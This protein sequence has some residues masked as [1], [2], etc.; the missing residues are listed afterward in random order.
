[1]RFTPA[2]VL[3]L[4]ATGLARAGDC[5]PATVDDDNFFQSGVFADVDVVL[6]NPYSGDEINVA[7]E[8]L[9]PDT[10]YDGME[11]MDII[12]GSNFNDAIIS[13]TLTPPPP[14]A[15]SV[16]SIEVI[17][18]GE[19]DDLVVLANPLGPYMT[20]PPQQPGNA[21]VS[22][23]GGSGNEII[24]LDATNDLAS[25]GSGSDHIDGGPGDDELYGDAGNDTVRGGD[26]NDIV[27]GG[28]GVNT[29]MGD[30]GSDT[31]I[32]LFTEGVTT[33]VEPPDGEI[34]A[35]GFLNPVA[36]DLFTYFRRGDD[37]IVV[38]EGGG[39]FII[40][41]QYS[42]PGRG[43]D[44]LRYDDAQPAI[45]LRGVVATPVGPCPTD[46][47][48]DCVTGSSDLAVLLASWG[49]EGAD[50]DNDG[51]TSSTDLAILLAAWGSCL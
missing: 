6:V 42:E 26:G 49:A 39:K 9:I 25:G 44:E 3:F 22:V 48:G 19:G 15:G 45:D 31:F 2:L 27:V 36:S 10:C 5:E 12:L 33:I 46:L 41:G 43:V 17:F 21:R 35:I 11:G 28:P 29:V 8:L 34:D 50:L 23:F 7:S 20:S 14:L 38:V 47:D 16:T 51:I 37:L 24:W 40:D 30:A 4:L 32:H 1:M 18:A 13:A